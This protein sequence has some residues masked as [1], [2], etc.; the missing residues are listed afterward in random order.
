MHTTTS[1]CRGRER[2]EGRARVVTVRPRMETEATK[3][4]GTH[5]Q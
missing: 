5:E 3:K 4:S 2:E 1:T